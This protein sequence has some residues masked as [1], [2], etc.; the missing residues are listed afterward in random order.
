MLLVIPA[1][2]KCIIPDNIEY[3]LKK[4]GSD[5]FEDIRENLSEGEKLFVICA[6][7]VSEEMGW[8]VAK[9]HLSLFGKSPLTG[10]N[11]DDLG[12][13]FP[14]LKNLYLSPDGSWRKGIACRVPDWKL[15]TPAELSVTG[16][17]V[18]VS[19]GID[20]AIIAG[21]GGAKVVLLVRIHSWSGLNETEPPLEELFIALKR[22]KGGEEL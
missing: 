13:R 9:D 6:D 20:E 8:I 11:R 18:L 7:G 22:K 2:W 17:S 15:C 10:A 21:H 16:A 3:L 14:S 1:E 4:S 12:P 19:E 5:I